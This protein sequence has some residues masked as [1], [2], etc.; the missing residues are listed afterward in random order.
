MERSLTSSIHGGMFPWKV[1]GI[2]ISNSIHR[3]QLAALQDWV[4]ARSGSIDTIYINEVPV[5]DSI[6]EKRFNEF[7]SQATQ[8]YGKNTHGYH[9]PFQYVEQWW[10]ESAGVGGIPV[11]VPDIIYMGGSSIRGLPL[12]F[13]SKDPDKQFRAFAGLCDMII[14]LESLH[15]KT[16]AERIEEAQRKKYL[17]QYH[18]L[19]IPI[20]TFYSK[21]GRTAGF[22]P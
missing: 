21:E 7:K 2:V 6:T 13:F 1:I 16:E 4:Y 19:G 20:V 10:R 14:V 11:K 12:N 22:R 9:S 3:K 5:G 18:N 15:T 8:Q 17:A